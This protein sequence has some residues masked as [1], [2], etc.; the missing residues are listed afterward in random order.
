[1]RILV[2]DDDEMVQQVCQGMLRALNHQSIV[3]SDATAAIQLLTESS[4]P[5]DCII[6]D[7]GLPGLSG[8]EL[9]AV[10]RARNMNVRVILISGGPP[11]AQA[12]EAAADCS[13]FEFLAKPFTL[14]DLSAAIERSQG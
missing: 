11:I 3:V 2:V 4:E 13:Q 14:S 1:V 7:N 8:L 9:L 5:F 6:L 10:L 12:D